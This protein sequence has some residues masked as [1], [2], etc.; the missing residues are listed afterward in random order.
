MQLLR[1]ES[2]GDISVVA[3]DQKN[4]GNITKDTSSTLIDD[5]YK[6]TKNG[7]GIESTS[8]G[9]KVDKIK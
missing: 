7:K 3:T 2:T 1:S 8:I 9:Q 4:L 5:A 6:P